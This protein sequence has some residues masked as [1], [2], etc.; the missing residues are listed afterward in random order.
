ME[1]LKE[2][3]SREPM[4]KQVCLSIFEEFPKKK[5]I[6]RTMQ[7]IESKFAQLMIQNINIKN[8]VVKI[9]GVQHGI[10]FPIIGSVE[11]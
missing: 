2:E 11:Q 3:E 1:S 9:G 5:Y 6:W 7:R 10:G 4:I 8:S